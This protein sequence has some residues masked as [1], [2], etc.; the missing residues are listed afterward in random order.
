MYSKP[1]LNYDKPCCAGWDR[2]SLTKLYAVC[3]K[4]VFCCV[5]FWDVPSDYMQRFIDGLADCHDEVEQLMTKGRDLQ[6]NANKSSAAVI[7]QQTSFTMDRWFSLDKQTKEAL[8]YL[9]VVWLN[10]TVYSIPI[11]ST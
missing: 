11:W 6:K 5:D 4:A 2:L 7:D 8:N 1:I 9:Q 10:Y 3:P